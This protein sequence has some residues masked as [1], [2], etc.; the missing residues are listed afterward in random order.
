[1]KNKSLIESFENIKVFTNVE[2]K[3]TKTSQGLVYDF[4]DVLSLI[5]SKSISAENASS[6]DIKKFCGKR[7]LKI[8]KGSKQEQLKF[9]FGE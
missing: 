8:T 6:D 5:R 7:G 9:P 1:M 2:P 4:S 3:V